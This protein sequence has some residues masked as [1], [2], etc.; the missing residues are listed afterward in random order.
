MPTITVTAPDSALAMDE[1]MRR[2]GDG[3]FILSTRSQDGQII[4][5]ATNDPIPAKAEKAEKAEKPTFGELFSKVGNPEEHFVLNRA[6]ENSSQPV[7]TRKPLVAVP[8]AQAGAHNDLS[9]THAASSPAG[10]DD[11][12]KPDSDA[13]AISETHADV[14]SLEFLESLFDRIREFDAVREAR[15]SDLRRRLER[16]VSGVDAARAA[17]D[18]AEAEARALE[19]V[20]DKQKADL[21]EMKAALVAAQQE[22]RRASEEDALLAIGFSA[23]LVGRLTAAESGNRHLAFASGLA[24]EIVAAQ[25]QLSDIVQGSGLVVVG[26]S[27]SGKSH[28]AAKFA[29][30]MQAKF[31][32]QRVKLVSVPYQ[33]ENITLSSL[34]R[35]IGIEHSYLEVEDLSDLSKFGPDVRLVFDINLPRETL[36]QL[37]FE[38]HNHEPLPMIVAMPAGQSAG[39]IRQTL[40]HYQTIA[41]QI[42][43]TKL[44]EYECDAA[45]LCAYAASP[46]PVG[47]LSGTQDIEGT[48]KEASVEVFRDYIIEMLGEPEVTEVTEVT[49]PMAAE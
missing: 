48:L 25:S 5:R 32:D 24:R 18:F 13:P 39:R 1:I 15:N 10:E 19:A 45:E 7:A 27:G 28:L 44:D 17:A 49:V 36:S 2:L 41:S 37:K 16:A 38:H 11:A 20:R 35:Q 8:N 4:I 21:Q 6:R 34:A 46:L 33:F 29:A 9:D 14:S 47:W 3:A 22:N 23:D 30:L 42:V 40:A 31:P 12:R 26:P 43:L